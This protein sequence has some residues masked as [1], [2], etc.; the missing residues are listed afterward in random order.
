M[1]PVL[2]DLHDRS[3]AISA[4]D[5][6]WELIAEIDGLNT[7]VLREHMHNS[8]RN[9]LETSLIDL[10]TSLGVDSGSRQ[11]ALDMLGD[12]SDAWVVIKQ[13]GSKGSF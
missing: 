12:G 4:L 1:I 7:S 9:T 5:R 11:D 3:E 6:V 8:V 2:V 13:Y 10:L